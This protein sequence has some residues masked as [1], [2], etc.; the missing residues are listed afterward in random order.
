[1]SHREKDNFITETEAHFG[2]RLL[3]FI[4]PRVKNEADAED[5][6]QEVWYHFSNLTNLSQ[7]V[8]VGNW[9][10]KATRNKI[11]DRYRKKSTENLEDMALGTGEQ[12]LYLQAFLLWDESNN[13]ELQFFQEEI[14]AALFEALEELPEKQRLVFIAH[15][16]EDKTLQQIAEEQQENL[17]TI[18]SRKQYAIKHLRSKLLPLYEDLNSY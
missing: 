10:Y 12:N 1:M 2:D 8:H 17:K 9:L 13:P 7:I 11:I 6:L 14:W 18:S 15:E 3:A 5:I 16:I 4:K